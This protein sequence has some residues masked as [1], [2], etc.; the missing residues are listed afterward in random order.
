MSDLA[1][2]L[3]W[4]VKFIKYLKA[5]EKYKNLG[6]SQLGYRRLHLRIQ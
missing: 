5:D 4:A 6:T 2:A 1:V 3:E